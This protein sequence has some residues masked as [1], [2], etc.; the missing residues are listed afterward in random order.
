MVVFPGCKINIG[1]NITGKRA[2]GFHFLQ[3][4]FYPINISDIL[5]IIPNKHFEIKTT[6]IPING[7]LEDN[8]VAKA[9]F[10]YKNKYNIPPVKIHLHKVVP[11]GAGLGGGSADAAATLVVLNSIFDL[12]I[13]NLDLQKDADLL[14]SDC[15]F[16]IKNKPALV[17]GKGEIITPASLHLKGFF[18]QLVYPKIHISTKDAF[19]NLNW[20][21]KQND[22]NKLIQLPLEN[23]KEHI[24]NDFESTVFPLHTEIEPI[25]TK[26]YK[27]GAIFASMTGTGSAVYGIFK[28]KPTLQFPNYFEKI[29]PLHY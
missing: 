20:S 18:I 23:W 1:L 10:L 26:L 27:N 8:L 14:G 25:K 16:F 5:E 12:N 3:S 15:A 29:I 17:Q 24:T 28:Q 9:Y 7:N 13:S 11:I 22:L 2:D 4:V 6:G 19:A 21:E